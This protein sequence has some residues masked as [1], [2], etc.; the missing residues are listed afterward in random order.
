[1][2]TRT[3]HRRDFSG[4]SEYSGETRENTLLAKD[5]NAELLGWERLRLNYVT[6]TE[7]I[8]APP[9]RRA[10][11]GFKSTPDSVIDFED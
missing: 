9:D 11:L 4:D 1:M 5:S 8:T 7:D 2:A 6:G 3:T 10:W